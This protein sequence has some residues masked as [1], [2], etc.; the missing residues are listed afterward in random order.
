[1]L[2]LGEALGQELQNPV[3]IQR[4]ATGSRKFRLLALVARLR[5]LLSGSGAA[6][7]LRGLRSFCTTY[8]EDFAVAVIAAA[9][10]G[11]VAGHGSAALTTDGQSRCAPAIGELTHLLLGKGLS[12]LRVGHECKCLAV[13]ELI[14]DVPHVLILSVGGVSRLL[15]RRG[16][17]RFKPALLGTFSCVDVAVFTSRVARKGQEDVFP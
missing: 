5:C 2:Q 14:E 12:A 15:R 3:T 6:I 4:R 11:H 8:V 16:C 9:G 13:L 10:A 7:G 1:M 17:C